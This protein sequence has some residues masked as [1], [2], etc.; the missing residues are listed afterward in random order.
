MLVILGTVF[1]QEGIAV[2]PHTFTADPVRCLSAIAA[3]KPIGLIPA[4]KS[5]GAALL[6]SSGIADDG[7]F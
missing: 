4:Q 1:A 6:G 5:N 3:G 7:N 2:I